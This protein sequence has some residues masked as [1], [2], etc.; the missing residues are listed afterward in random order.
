MQ[1]RLAINT[2]CETGMNQYWKRGKR[3]EECYRAH[4]SHALVNRLLKQKQ[5]DAPPRKTL[6]I[7]AI[8]SESARNNPVSKSSSNLDF[9]RQW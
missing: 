8:E 7:A 4:T 5:N 1:N 2:G 9:S 6:L 3:E